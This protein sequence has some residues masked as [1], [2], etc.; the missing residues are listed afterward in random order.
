MQALDHTWDCERARRLVTL[1]RHE[2]Q[3]NANS[4]K[5]KGPGNDN[6]WLSPPA[7][8]S[9][10]AL[11]LFSLPAFIQV[12]DQRDSI[13]GDSQGVNYT[14]GSQGQ[15]NLVILPWKTG[16]NFISIIIIIV[17]VC[18]ALG[19]DKKDSMCRSTCMYVCWSKYDRR[20]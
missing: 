18:L 16:R 4:A 19:I 20:K 15:S 6:L 5:A 1:P 17:V 3:P 8:R 10:G 2:T 9:I 13:P 12:S 7:G 14:Q 11:K